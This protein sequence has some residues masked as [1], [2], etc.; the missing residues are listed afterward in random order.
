MSCLAELFSCLRSRKDNGIDD[1]TGVKSLIS[2][3][4]FLLHPSNASLLPAV[5]ESSSHRL[6][7][8]QRP[9]RPQ[10]PE[11]AYIVEK[12]MVYPPDPGARD[13]SASVDYFSDHNYTTVI[14]KRKESLAADA[15][16]YSQKYMS[17]RPQ[18]ITE[19][20]D[21]SD[22]RDNRG[23]WGTSN[24]DIG[25]KQ[26]PKIYAGAMSPMRM[27]SP[28]SKAPVATDDLVPSSSFFSLLEEY[29]PSP[30][31]YSSSLGKS[32]TYREAT[33]SLST[34]RR[35]VNREKQQGVTETVGSLDRR[36]PYHQKA[37]PDCLEDQ[38]V[39]DSA[40][41][42][43]NLDSGRGVAD[44]HFSE[45]AT[46]LGITSDLYDKKKL[47]DSSGNT[48]GI[49]SRR[50]NNSSA[51]NK[52]IIS[53]GEDS[54]SSGSTTNLD[55][56]IN[57]SRIRA[58][59]APSRENLISSESLLSYGPTKSNFRKGNFLTPSEIGALEESA[60]LLS[61]VQDYG[62][63]PHT[64]D[65]SIYSS[66]YTSRP[67]LVGMRGSSLEISGLAFPSAV[68]CSTTPNQT[69]DSYQALDA[70][71]SKDLI[72]VPIFYPPAGRVRPQ[73]IRTIRSIYPDRFPH[74]SQNS[75]RVTDHNI[76]ENRR[77]NNHKVGEGINNIQVQQRSSSYGA[78]AARMGN[79]PLT[80]ADVSHEE[81][82]NQ[83]GLSF[84]GNRSFSPRT[85]YSSG[86]AGAPVASSEDDS[87]MM[88]RASTTAR[89]LKSSISLGDRLRK[90]GRRNGGAEARR[91]ASTNSLGNHTTPG[92]ENIDE[93]DD[94]KNKVLGRRLNMSQ[95]LSRL[96]NRIHPMSGLKYELN[97]K[98]PGNTAVY[99]LSSF[100][101]GGAFYDKDKERI[102]LESDSEKEIEEESKNSMGIDKSSERV[103]ARRTEN[104]PIEPSSGSLG[105]N[106]SNIE[107]NPGLNIT[108]YEDCVMLPFSLT[109]FETLAESHCSQEKVDKLPSHLNIPTINERIS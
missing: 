42:Q 58:L 10:R 37:L 34:E 71:L 6:P 1:S 70:R 63:S 45:F 13:S 18:L 90:H 15:A 100:K 107:A 2:P 105:N 57:F 108:G 51:L 73:D 84:I 59:V 67:S 87:R 79:S 77:D 19:N 46:E 62:R 93:N 14:R 82:S 16:L 53:P 97:P 102:T 81:Y 5:G 25:L 49:S 99:H 44:E 109:S 86:N 104:R 54:S 36:A 7:A 72:G 106:V 38:T 74:C 60:N 17:S 68:P 65:S 24:D 94:T 22:N 103:L 9:Q 80:F 41:S 78:A 28:S 89:R 61:S 39:D 91:R 95:S 29:D 8:P 33:L 11:H 20:Q 76:F 30:V 92:T 4:A 96:K 26:L 43:E 66:E 88:T 52:P 98:T 32:G 56:S 83:P 50:G 48:I 55:S 101:P 75:R 21:M 47:E 64:D 23:D 85:G 35:D 31:K 27:P 40:K 3:S 69:P 12:G